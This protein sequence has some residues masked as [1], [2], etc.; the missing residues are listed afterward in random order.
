MF[1]PLRDEVGTLVRI[2]NVCQGIGN[3]N[4]VNKERDYL[5][6]KD[7]PGGNYQR[8]SMYVSITVTAYLEA[9]RKG[10]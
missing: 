10:K 1:S 6:W 7:I 4:E 2:N 3:R 5:F 9:S 8:E